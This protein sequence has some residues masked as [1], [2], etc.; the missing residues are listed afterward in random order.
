MKTKTITRI[1]FIS[2]NALR[3]LLVSLFNMVIPFLV[4]HYSSKAVWGSFVSLLLFSLLVLQF[5]NWGNKEFLLRQFSQFPNKI[6]ENYSR[7]FITRL[8]LVILSGLIG[9]FYFPVGFNALLFLWIFG[10]FLNQS[11]EA[12]VIFEKKFNAS[13]LIELVGFAVFVFCMYLKQS[14]DVYDLLLLYSCYQVMKGIWYFLLFKKYFT[15]KNIAIEW[16]YYQIAFPFFLL[17]I[18]GFLASKVDVYLVNHLGDTIVTANYQVINSL[19]V[20][21]MTLS[22]FIYAPFTKNIYRNSD[23]VI[24][25][26]RHL[27]M[28]LGLFIVPMALFFIYFVLQYY[29]VNLQLPL[30]F[31]A[32]AF[33]YIYPSFLYG[34]EV[35][36]L[37]K[38]HQEK[39]VV[40]F[41]LVGA[42]ANTLFS[43]AFLYFNYG[44]LGALTGSA[45]AQLLVLGLFKFELY[46]EK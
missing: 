38:L 22:S 2:N 19:L 27:L 43:A 6:N 41:L 40:R 5:I 46:R 21:T 14:V 13:M 26:T 30:L 36:N 29:Y 15:I 3:Q 20:F 34:I 23:A 39:T 1:G 17:S 44:I 7:I 33:V 11:V 8:P 24:K 37:F 25:K 12:L 9:L 18:L 31:Y 45:I 32:V 10:R 16:K 4:I 35:I 28:M 42:L